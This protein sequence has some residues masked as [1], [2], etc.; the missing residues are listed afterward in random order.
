M[1][2][3]VSCPY[4]NP[5]KIIVLCILIFIFLDSR[6]EDKRLRTA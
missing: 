5:D 3:K 1:K 4:E 6:Q 2:E